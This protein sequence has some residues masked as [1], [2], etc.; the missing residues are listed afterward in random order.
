MGRITHFLAR[1]DWFWRLTPQKRR[2]DVLIRKIHAFTVSI[3]QN[4][5]EERAKLQPAETKKHT[6]LLDILLDATIDGAPLSVKDIHEEVDNFM[7]A[8]HDTTT[9][10]IEFLLYNLAKYPEIQERVY[11]EVTDVLGDVEHITLNKLR[12]LHYLDLVIKE[13][14]RLFPPVPMVARKL[15]E[16]VEISMSHSN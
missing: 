6:A 15:K 8:G 14:L 10:A 12:D 2:H 16:E 7:F 5:Q 11:Q 9:C 4:R 3:I 13:S 1:D